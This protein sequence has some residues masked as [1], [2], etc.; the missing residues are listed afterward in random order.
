MRKPGKALVSYLQHTLE[1]YAHTSAG[2]R[3][4]T[5]RPAGQLKLPSLLEIYH[6]RMCCGG[7][8]RMRRIKS[9]ACEHRRRRHVCSFFSL[10]CRHCPSQEFQ[11]VQR[12][13]A[14]FFFP[15]ATPRNSPNLD[16]E[17][18]GLFCRSS[19]C[20]GTHRDLAS[21]AVHL[22]FRQKALHAFA[23]SLCKPSISYVILAF[24]E[25]PSGT[26]CCRTANL[27]NFILGKDRG[28]RR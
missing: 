28:T 3:F 14:P 5:A 22:I 15:L 18:R 11:L 9:F 7:P 17:A 23:H 1:S 27:F 12:T 6:A 24:E 21:E 8:L 25:G 13:S 4:G 10:S 20:S 19:V 2:F 26:L 16:D